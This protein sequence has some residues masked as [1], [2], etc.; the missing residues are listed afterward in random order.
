[1]KQKRVIIVCLFLHYFVF[2]WWTIKRVYSWVILKYAHV[3]ATKQI[4][5][6]QVFKA[7]PSLRISSF[8]LFKCSHIHPS[9]SLG[10]LCT[11]I[12]LSGCDNSIAFAED[13]LPT[14]EPASRAVA[15][16]PAPQPAQCSSCHAGLSLLWHCESHFLSYPQLLFWNSETRCRE[17]WQCFTTSIR[18]NAFIQV[19]Y[20]SSVF[21][22]HL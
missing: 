13:G 18:V 3:R 2:Q 17:I 4:T 22:L 6:Y 1:M 14:E 5:I 21:I 7:L 16:R 15:K 10:V 20:V 9:S 12:P 8:W 11:S 19:I